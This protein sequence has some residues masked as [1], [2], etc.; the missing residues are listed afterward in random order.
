[1]DNVRNCD[2]YINIPSSQTYKS[3]LKLA[4]RH[5]MMTQRNSEADQGPHT[6]MKIVGTADYALSRVVQIGTQV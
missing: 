3:N 4:E 6:L 5:R 1:M 2:S